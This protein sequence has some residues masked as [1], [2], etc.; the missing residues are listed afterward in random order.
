MCINLGGAQ[1]EIKDGRMQDMPVYMGF[2]IS[3]RSRNRSTLN[4]DGSRL[5]NSHF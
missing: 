1:D 2:R 5:T 3:C 4:L